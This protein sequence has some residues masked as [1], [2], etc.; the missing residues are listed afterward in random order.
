MRAGFLG[1]AAALDLIGRAVSSGRLPHALLLHGPEG[2]GKSEVARS[3]ASALLC[4]ERAE[5]SA[6]GCGRCGDS[7]RRSGAGSRRGSGCSGA[8]WRGSAGYCS[9]SARQFRR[10]WHDERGGCRRSWT[11]GRVRPDRPVATV[12]GIP[13]GLR[14]V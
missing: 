6:W 1:N 2:V 4:G 13:C 9:D 14:T 3:L 12:I 7:G 5:G 8:R 10:T 11:A